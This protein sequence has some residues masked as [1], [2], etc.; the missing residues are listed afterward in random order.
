M[1]EVTV[2]YL[3]ANIG[4]LLKLIGKEGRCQ[5]CPAKIWWIRHSNGK[6]VA[7]TET[8]LNHF[9]DCPAKDQFKKPFPPKDSSHV[10]HGGK[11]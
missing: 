3:L 1:A 5:G 8:G 2:D 6:T 4:R 9:A 7:Y 10:G 11:P